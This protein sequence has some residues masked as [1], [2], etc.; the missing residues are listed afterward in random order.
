MSVPRKASSVFVEI[1]GG[2]PQ[3]WTSIFIELAEVFEA[4]FKWDILELKLEYEQVLYAIQMQLHQWLG[5]DFYLRG[6]SN[7]V[8]GFYR[9]RDVWLNIFNRYNVEFK[10]EYLQEG[11]N[12]KRAHKIK[13][14]LELAGV[15]IGAREASEIC[16]EYL[17][18]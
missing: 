5:V 1:L 15:K 4:L 17:N 6:C 9:R 2:R 8:E 13:K 18:S 10:N 16:L 3:K 12:Y 11:S 14:A 7:A